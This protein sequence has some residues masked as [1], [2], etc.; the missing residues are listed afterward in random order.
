MK[1]RKTGGRQK[2]TPNKVSLSFREAVVAL[3]EG[4][5]LPALLEEVSPEK[6]LEVIC[7]LAEYAFPKL[8][9]T[10]VVGEGGG[11]LVVEVIRYADKAPQPIPAAGLS[12]SAAPVP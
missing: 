6:R 7:K 10:E 9:R 3:I 5:D 1:G 4:Q 8:G 2:G 11:P 12:A